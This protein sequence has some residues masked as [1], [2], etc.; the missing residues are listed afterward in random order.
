MTN[1]VPDMKEVM[2]ETVSQFTGLTDRNGNRIWENDIVRWQDVSGKYYH[3]VVKFG[4]Y[5]NLDFGFYL[6]WI[7][8]IWMRPNISYWTDKVKVVGNVFNNPEFL[9]VGNGN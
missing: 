2:P 6:T 7:E 8:D 4:E 5:G 9:E 1:S 3:A